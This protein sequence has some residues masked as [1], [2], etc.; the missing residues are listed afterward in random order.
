M[1]EMK[2]I[3]IRN[4]YVQYPEEW[5]VLEPIGLAKECEHV[6]VVHVHAKEQEGV[7]C[8]MFFSRMA[9]RELSGED[10]RTVLNA[11]V[12]VYPELHPFVE[13]GLLVYPPIIRINE[14]L[15]KGEG[16]HMGY[17]SKEYLTYPFDAMVVRSPK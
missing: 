6:G 16:E 9:I 8:F 2:K 12:D 14:L 15:A 4:G 17:N 11:C 5:V 10:V 7:P 3:E 13:V 1:S